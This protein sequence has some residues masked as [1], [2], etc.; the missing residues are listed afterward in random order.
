M[1]C[2][3]I[4]HALIVNGHKITLN[5]DYKDKDGNKYIIKCITMNDYLKDNYSNEKKKIDNLSN[6]NGI[7]FFDIAFTDATGHFDLV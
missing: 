3:R 1:C 6:K 7:V 2:V 4:S 5:S